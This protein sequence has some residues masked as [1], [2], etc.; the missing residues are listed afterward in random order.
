MAVAIPLRR[1]LHRTRLVP[2]AAIGL[3]LDAR[4]C[5]VRTITGETRVER[6]DL[7]VLDNYRFLHGRDAFRGTRTLHVLSVRTTEAF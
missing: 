4:A 6:Y 5:V 2:G 1:T 3:D 7:L